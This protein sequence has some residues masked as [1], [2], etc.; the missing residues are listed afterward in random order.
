MRKATL[1]VALL[2][3]QVL[4][5]TVSPTASFAAHGAL[6][7]PSGQ[8]TVVTVNAAQIYTPS[9][10]KLTALAEALHERPTTTAGGN[11]YAPDAI[12]VNEIPGST[13]SNLANKLNLLFDSTVASYEVVGATTD[14]VK[15]KILVNKVTVSPRLSSSWVDVC[16]SARRYQLVNLTEIASGKTLTLAGIHFNKGYGSGSCRGKNALE[17]RKRV[18]AQDTDGSVVGDFNRRAMTVER[19]CDPDETSGDQDWY[20]TMTAFSSVDSR[21]YIDSVRAYHRETGQTMLH[22]WTHEWPDT[23]TLCNG[24]T[25]HRRNRIDYIFVSDT[26]KPIEAHADHPGWANQDVSGLINP[27][28]TT[29][30]CKYSDH[31]FTWALV[32]LAPSAPAEPA[33]TPA[34]D[35]P[36]GVTATATSST[37]IGVGWNDV[38][39]E[40]GYKIERSP[41]GQT[42]WTQ[43]ATTAAGATTYSDG[44]LSADTTY[45]YR[46][47]ATNGG[48]D[49]LPSAIASATTNADAIAPSAP[50]GLTAKGTK[51]RID[52]AWTVS[53]DSGGSGLAEYQIYRSTTGSEPFELRAT[54]G[55]SATSYRDTAVTKAATYW[56]YVRAVDKAGNSANSNTASAKVR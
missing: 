24:D 10:G 37:D 47:K 18:A 21:T 17:V 3:V 7:S 42:S 14:D 34:P 33:P 8:I 13:L 19:E 54:V 12:V 40:T 23:S 39:N 1:A 41:D 48:G 50:G 27:D 56:Y 38:A 11:Y 20:K 46:V 52:L 43:V 49:S 25:G 28:C 51:G 44:G 2:A 30:D 16:D 5:L 26:M 22:E 35:A 55:A 32:D 6:P 29:A 9:E 31:R 53:S 36:S 45:Y 15:A 4:S